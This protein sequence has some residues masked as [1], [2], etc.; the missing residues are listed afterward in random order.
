MVPPR[1]AV[2][3]EKLGISLYPG[4]GMTEGGNL[5]S[6]NID[7]K[8]KPESVGKIYPGQETK[9]VDGE[10]WFRGDNTFLGYYKD[11]ENTKATLTE[12]GWVKTGDL[13]RFD[14]EG[15]LYIVGR[16]KNLII[17]SNGENI[18]PEVVEDRFYKYPTVKDCLV[19][20]EDGA[21]SIEILPVMQAFDGKSWEEIE[22]YFR[23]LVAKVN[24]DSPS[25]QRI[26]KIKVRQEDFKRTGSMKVARNQ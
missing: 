8:T 26:S 18:S 1:I 19:K 9:V 21:I 13:V 2:E 23:D 11:P 15:Y 16:I 20:E 17:L 12:D 14:E 6:A 10:L 25:V 24:A 5:T 7:V 4:Y 22:A 3:F